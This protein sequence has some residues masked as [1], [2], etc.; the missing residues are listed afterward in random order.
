MAFEK[1]HHKLIT[2]YEKDDDG[3]ETPIKEKVSL[4]KFD[5]IPFGLIR[6]NRKLPQ[7]EQFFALLEQVASEK[8]LERMDRAPQFEM[9]K[10]MQAWQEDSG[11][12]P[13]ESE[14]S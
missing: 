1:F 14:A 12:T 5:Q 3:N 2:G 4:P 10:L 13:G 6:K 11:V 9:E 7:E 8:D